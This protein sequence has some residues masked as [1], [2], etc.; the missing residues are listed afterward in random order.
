MLLGNPESSVHAY[1]FGPLT[2]KTRQITHTNKH[3]STTK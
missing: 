2:V 1:Q 3:K